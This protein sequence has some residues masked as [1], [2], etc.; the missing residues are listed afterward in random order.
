MVKLNV[1]S[2]IEKSGESRYSLFNKINNIR[3]TKGTSAIS[4]TNF[5]NLIEMKNQSVRYQDLDELCE[6]L[7][8]DLKDILVRVE[9]EKKE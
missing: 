3:A 1:L 2:L 6:A 9:G 5:L 7:D 4:Y 8:C